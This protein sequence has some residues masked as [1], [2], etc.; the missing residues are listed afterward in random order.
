MGAVVIIVIVHGVILVHADFEGQITQTAAKVCKPLAIFLG[1]QFD[2]VIYIVALSVRIH[3]D[4]FLLLL[5]IDHSKIQLI[6]I[7]T[8]IYSN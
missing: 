3:G 2:R 8:N 5:I 7:S 4:K 1:T 6:L